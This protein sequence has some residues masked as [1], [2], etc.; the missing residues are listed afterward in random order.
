M[1]EQDIRNNIAL[2]M[3]FVADNYYSPKEQMFRSCVTIQGGGGGG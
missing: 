1:I 2:E 3:G